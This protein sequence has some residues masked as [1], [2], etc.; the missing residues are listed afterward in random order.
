METPALDAHRIVKYPA[1]VLKAVSSEVTEFGPKLR[2]LADRMLHLM[3]A[4]EG[5]GL[6]APQVGLNVRLFVC[7]PTGQ[8]DDDLV[9]VNPVLADLVGAED[10]PEGCL[11]I[12]G[13]TVT[14]RRAVELTLEASDVEGRPFRRTGEGLVARIWQHETDHL[15]GRLIIDRMSETD[16]IANR[17]VLK[18]LKEEYAAGS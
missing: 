9:C 2:A 15:N 16:A 3:R 7:N 1:P 17:R 5:V 18:Q 12:P 4:S 10:A 11:S 14:M 6:A 8:P 13:V